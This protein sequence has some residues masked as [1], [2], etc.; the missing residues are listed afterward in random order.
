MSTYIFIYLL[1]KQERGK[2][3]GKK[4]KETG[5]QEKENSRI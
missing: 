2:E 3:K 1:D 4:E 5:E